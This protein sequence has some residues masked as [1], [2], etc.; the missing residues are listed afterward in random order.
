MLSG[1]RFRLEYTDKGK[2]TLQQQTEKK[3]KKAS[4]SVI[5]KKFLIICSKTLVLNESMYIYITSLLHQYI[6]VIK[7]KQF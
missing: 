7:K 1:L 6:V 5:D 4:Y 3:F 2:R